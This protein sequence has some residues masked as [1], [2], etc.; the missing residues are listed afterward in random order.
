MGLQFRSDVST[1]DTEY[2]T[3]LLDERSGCYWQLNPTGVLVVR[4]LLAGGTPTQAVTALTEEFDVDKP[5]A[6][7]D[8][9]ALVDQLRSAGLVTP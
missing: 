6:M 4:T 3:V 5:Q 9:T 1:A 8:V 2:G 7:Q